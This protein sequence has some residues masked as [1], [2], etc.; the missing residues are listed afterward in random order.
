MSAY[1]D[2]RINSDY[3]EQPESMRIGPAY[4]EQPETSQMSYDYEQ[5]ESSE[6]E[7]DRYDYASPTPVDYEVPDNVSDTTPETPQRELGRPSAPLPPKMIKDKY[8]PKVYTT[9]TH[10]HAQSVYSTPSHSTEFRT[11]AAVSGSMLDITSIETALDYNGTRIAVNKETDAPSKSRARFNCKV[12]VFIF[13]IVAVVI[14][15]ISLVVSVVAVIVTRETGSADVDLMEEMEALQKEVT[16][17]QM[18]VEQ[19]MNRTSG[20]VDLSELYD[21]CDMDDDE[22]PCNTEIGINVEP[23]RTRD[24]QVEK[25]VSDTLCSIFRS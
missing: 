6:T 21:A 19:A 15:M 11:N 3:Y 13:L 23:C 9:L 14:G 22:Q 8:R 18:T 24:L 12:A 25:E 17:L 16:E 10:T 20:T 1:R 4:Y 2:S 5:P 7:E